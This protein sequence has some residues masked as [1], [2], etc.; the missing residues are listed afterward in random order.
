M[1]TEELI[2]WLA[3]ESSVTPA[4]A[5]DQL[6]SAVARIVKRLR[7]GS[8]VALPGIGVLEQGQGHS[9]VLKPAVPKPGRR[10]GRRA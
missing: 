7:R 10:T 2:T 6:E 9:I 4:A 5:A 1:N 3:R 8:P